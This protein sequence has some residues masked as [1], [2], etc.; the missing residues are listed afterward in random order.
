MW[1]G[2]K[3]FSGSLYMCKIMSCKSWTLNMC[4]WYSNTIRSTYCSLITHQIFHSH[5][6]LFIQGLTGIHFQSPTL[7]SLYKSKVMLFSVRVSLQSINTFWSSNEKMP[8][9]KN[10]NCLYHVIHTSLLMLPSESLALITE[11]TVF[12]GFWKWNGQISALSYLHIL[13]CS[14]KTLYPSF[15]SN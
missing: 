5:F 8:K 9:K 7:V 12:V 13:N 6:Y 4:L 3:H 2:S 10:P 11:P 15:H 1:K 14:N